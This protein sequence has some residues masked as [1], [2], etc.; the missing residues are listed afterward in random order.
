M[1]LFIY[2]TLQHWSRM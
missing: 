2:C 1:P